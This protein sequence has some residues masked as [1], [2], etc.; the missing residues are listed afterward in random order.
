MF[1]FSDAGNDDGGWLMMKISDEDED[2]TV[3][4]EYEDED[5]I[6]RREKNPPVK[7][8]NPTC[9]LHLFQKNY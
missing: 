8:G 2:M 1:L 4:D 9:L 3:M 5:D 7:R 6:N